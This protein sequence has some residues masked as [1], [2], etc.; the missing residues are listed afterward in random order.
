MYRANR[1]FLILILQSRII[2]GAMKVLGFDSK[3]IQPSL[4]N[5]PANVA[6]KTNIDKLAIL[7]EAAGLVIDKFVFV[8]NS[9]DK[10][11][12]K[13]IT[14]QERQD[15]LDSQQLTSDGRFPCRFQG[16]KR[17]FKYDGKSRKKHEMS[18]NPPP[19][20]EEPPVPTETTKRFERE[21]HCKR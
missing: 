19:N 2:T 17:S 9:I 11:I 4:F 1:D 13:V 10:H 14:E 8:E 7:H 18:H 21:R 12:S 6:S 3:E 16:C 15:I 5:I 20:V